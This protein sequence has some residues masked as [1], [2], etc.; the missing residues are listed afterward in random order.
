MWQDSPRHEHIAF[1]DQPNTLHN[2]LV[3]VGFAFQEHVIASW[4]SIATHDIMQ[5]VR[6]EIQAQTRCQIEG[7]GIFPVH[8]IKRL[9]VSKLQRIL[10][11][12]KWG[13]AKNV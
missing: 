12:G 13:L 10:A 7:S 3:V 8:E 6:D 5:A 9:L 2:Q 4:P 11:F 1:H